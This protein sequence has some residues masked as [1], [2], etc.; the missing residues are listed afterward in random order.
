M[1]FA[2]TKEINEKGYN[3]YVELTTLCQK[4]IFTAMKTKQSVDLNLIP[5]SIISGANLLLNAK[6]VRINDNKN[7]LLLPLQLMHLLV[8]SRLYT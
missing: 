8:S 5:D 1:G 6:A 7:S 2:I 3:K 4:I